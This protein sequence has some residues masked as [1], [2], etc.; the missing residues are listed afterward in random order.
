MYSFT[1]DLLRSELFTGGYKFQGRTCQ[2]IFLRDEMTG[3]N[4]GLVE[5]MREEEG[6]SLKKQYLTF[7]S[8]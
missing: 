4:E 6:E 3:S 2:E 5:K 8:F 7:P 1:A